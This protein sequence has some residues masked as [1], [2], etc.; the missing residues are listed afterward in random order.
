MSLSLEQQILSE[1]LDRLKGPALG[2][3]GRPPDLAVERSRLRELAHCQL[4]ALSIYPLEAVT[5]RKGCLRETTLTVKVAIWAKSTAS[6][7]VDQE[8]DPL[9]QWVHQQVVTD[10]SMGGLAQKVEPSQKIWGFAL[11]QAPFGDLDLHYL[12]TFKHHA[13]NPTLP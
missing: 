9:W 8:L 7:P 5:V 6:V 1:M 11:H 13:E 4:P 2:P 12:I 10:P 3:I